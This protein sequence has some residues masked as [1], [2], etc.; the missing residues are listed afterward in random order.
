MHRRLDL[1]R[2]LLELTLVCGALMAENKT[3]SYMCGLLGT[4]NQRTA[5]SFGKVDIFFQSGLP[6]VS[7]KCIM[8]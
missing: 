7:Y 6:I 5:A 2:G 3:C 4:E 1:C 8:V